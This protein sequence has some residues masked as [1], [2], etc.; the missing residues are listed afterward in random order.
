MS[1]TIFSGPTSIICPLLSSPIV[2][3]KVTSYWI[4]NIIERIGESLIDQ[5]YIWSAFAN[6]GVDEIHVTVFAVNDG[7]FGF[8]RFDPLCLN[9]G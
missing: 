2:I 6:E 3:S 7:E 5:I 9:G 1:E 8:L 4:I